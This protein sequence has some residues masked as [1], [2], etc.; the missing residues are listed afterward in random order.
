MSMKDAMRASSSWAMP[1]LL[2]QVWIQSTSYQPVLTSPRSLSSVNAASDYLNM[3]LHFPW[4]KDCLNASKAEMLAPSRDVNLPL[5][6][7]TRCPRQ[8]SQQSNWG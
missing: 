1:V 8:I 4:G 7:R 2:L 5:R 6:N 3:R